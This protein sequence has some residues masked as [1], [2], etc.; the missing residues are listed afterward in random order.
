MRPKVERTNQSKL[1]EAL[2]ITDRRVRQLEDQG[3]LVR[4]CLG[5]PRLANPRL[6]GYQYHLTSP[7]E[8][9]VK[10]CLKYIKLVCPTDD[11]S[12]LIPAPGRQIAHAD[13]IL[14]MILDAASHHKW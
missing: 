14:P 11:W 4:D 13:A 6:T 12:M 10:R 8:H 3:V 1:A 2:A 9:A 7:R 5:T